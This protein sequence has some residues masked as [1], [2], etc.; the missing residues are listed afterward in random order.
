MDEEQGILVVM[1]VGGC[2]DQ[3]FMTGLECSL[4]MQVDNYNKSK[5][6]FC[7]LWGRQEDIIAKGNTEGVW[8]DG[9][10]RSGLYMVTWDVYFMIIH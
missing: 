3:G 2:L 4:N 5:V 1:V 10:A 6:G 8:N 7:F 9:N